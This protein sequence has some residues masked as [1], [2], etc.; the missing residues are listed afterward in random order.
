MILMYKICVI[1]GR[2]TVIGFKAL[3]LDTY[4]VDNTDD[5]KRILR[6]LSEPESNCAII[7]LEENLAEALKVQIDRIKERPSPA[8]ILIPGREGS[9][10][11]GMRELYEAVDKAVGVAII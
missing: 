10:G 1:G 9:L 11:I 6:E 3:G 4:P 5:A 2:D 7:Y 8:V